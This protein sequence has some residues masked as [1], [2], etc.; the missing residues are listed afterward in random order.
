MF[1][2][3]LFASFAYIN[4]VFCCALWCVVAALVF[5]LLAHVGGHAATHAHTATSTN[6]PCQFVPLRAGRIPP[7]L[8]CLGEQ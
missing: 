6:G 5:V 3:L 4:R 8:R 1:N 2:P 7:R